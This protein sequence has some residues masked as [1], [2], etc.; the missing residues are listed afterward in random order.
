MSRKGKS[1]PRPATTGA[2]AGRTGRRNRRR[3][4]NS[5]EQALWAH[6][7][8]QVTPLHPI[9]VPE[10]VAV[11]EAAAPTIPEPSPAPGKDPAPPRAART[12][13]PPAPPPPIPLAA[14]EP[15][16][17]RRLSRGAEV[18]ARLDLHG[19]T[20]AAAH[21]RLRLFLMEA[22]ALGYS[23]VLV[24]TGKGDAQKFVGPE[25]GI[26]GLRGARIVSEPAYGEERGVLRRAVPHW[27]ASPDMRAVVVGFEGAARRHGGEGALYVRIRRR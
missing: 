12:K 18:D 11:P 21:Q 26:G 6:V 8:R 4:L 9:P 23:V 2:V 7:A 5:E 19:L 25:T 1:T 14:L 22:Q 3:E 16:A 20:Q 27:L 15:K 24:I 10:P 17:R 13:K